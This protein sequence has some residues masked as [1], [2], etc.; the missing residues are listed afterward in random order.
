VFLGWVLGYGILRPLIEIV[1]DDDDRGLYTLPGTHLQLSTSQII[2]VVSCVLGLALMAGLIRKYRRD[3]AGS[4]LWEIPLPERATE[5]GPPA[6]GGSGGA[7]GSTKSS[8]KRRKR[9]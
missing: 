7:A 1:R 3:P 2:G 5:S 6:T 4:R 9:R 8:P